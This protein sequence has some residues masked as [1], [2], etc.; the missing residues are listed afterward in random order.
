MM[1]HKKIGTAS[2]FL[3]SKE[4]CLRF[5]SSPNRST[6]NII[7]SIPNDIMESDYYPLFAISFTLLPIC[8]VMVATRA[9]TAFI[10]AMYS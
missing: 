6:N 10:A 7:I 2:G 8:S 1:G 5:T 4:R 3:L 9:L